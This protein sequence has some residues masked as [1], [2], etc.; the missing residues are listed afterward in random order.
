MAPS[1]LAMDGLGGTRDAQNLR[2]VGSPG[3]MPWP[4]RGPGSPGPGLSWEAPADSRSTPEERFGNQRHLGGCCKGSAES[5]SPRTTRHPHLGIRQ[6]R[7][8]TVR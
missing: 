7:N 8:G 5:L 1:T 2:A 4:A 6:A 3:G